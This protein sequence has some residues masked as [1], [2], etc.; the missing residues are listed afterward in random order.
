MSSYKLAT[1]NISSFIDDI[2][3]RNVMDTNEFLKH[4]KEYIEGDN[5]L[6]D[7]IRGMLLKRLKYSTGD[8]YHSIGLRVKIT[9]IP[10]KGHKSNVGGWTF[11]QAWVTVNLYVPKRLLNALLGEDEARADVPS[12]QELVRWI[13]GKQLYFRKSID[14]IRRKELIHKAL[15]RQRS[16]LNT[17]S[18]RT[19]LT[20]FPRDAAGTKYDNPIEALAAEIRYKMEK[21]LEK[22]KSATKGSEYIFLGHT[23]E[24]MSFAGK[25]HPVL[26]AIYKKETPALFS[27]TEKDL[28]MTYLKE[29]TT[30]FIG[31]ILQTY[32]VRREPTPSGIK[33]TLAGRET[34]RLFPEVVHKEL[35]EGI[36]NLR[37]ILRRLDKIKSRRRSRERYEIENYL[38]IATDMMSSLILREAN[39]MDKEIRFKALDFA[40]RIKAISVKTRKRKR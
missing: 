10:A 3:A 17:D 26:R 31:N 38:N 2:I 9:H 19:Y 34:T 30:H 8:L 20:P 28:I 16:I 23:R 4:L 11:P 33:S 29:H 13:R 6:I 25:E 36:D 14:N 12:V 27:R 7:T 37:E 5:S 40:K 22:K 1:M 21:R 35:E 15:H 24:T 18:A 39:M 32:S